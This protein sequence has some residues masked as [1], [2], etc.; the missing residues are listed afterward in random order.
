MVPG[1]HNT[2]TEQAGAEGCM[3]KLETSEI[4]CRAQR[5]S[6][7]VYLGPADLSASKKRREPMYG[8]MLKRPFDQP[9][10][11]RDLFSHQWR[12]QDR[13]ALLLHR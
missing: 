7:Y 6:T 4:V 13:V 8:G 1:Q 2:K 10:V 5:G 9:N 3:S 12:V 11:F